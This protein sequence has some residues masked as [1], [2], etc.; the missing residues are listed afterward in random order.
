M[1][2][3]IISVML[4][5]V[6]MVSMVGVVASA[7]TGVAGSYYYTDIKTYTRGQLMTSYNVGGKTVIVAEDLRSYGFE[8]VW[9]GANRTLTIKDVHGPASSNATSAKTGPIGAVA[10]SYYHTDIVTYFDGKKIESYNLNG[11]T[12]IPAT[13]LRD[14]G[15][16]VV[17]D[18]A[19]RKVYINDKTDDFTD[20]KIKANQSYHGTLSLVKEPVTFNGQRLI[21]SDNFYIETKLDKKVYVPF[22][23]IADALGIKYTWNS[24][25]ATVTVTVP[26]DKDIKPAKTENKKNS[27]TYGTVEYELKDIELIIAN[28]NEKYTVDAAVYGSKVMVEAGDFAKALG[29]FCLNQSD[30]YTTSM[31]YLLYSGMVK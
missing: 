9:N 29:M 24:A 19:N 3:K 23:P 2:K 21:T 8:V 22:K 26:E 25:T 1:F 4:A 13:L 27:K 7:A 17:W 11:V 18:G 15:Y 31:M 16:D 30:I 20:V 6:I 5:T 28:G 14:F 12:V 10:G